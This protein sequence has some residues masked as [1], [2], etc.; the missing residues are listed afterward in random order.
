MSVPAGALTNRPEL[1]ATANG[2]WVHVVDVSDT[3]SGPDGTSK[4]VQISNLLGLE[5]QTTGFTISR[6]I[7]TSKT[8]TISENATISAGVNISGMLTVSNTTSITNTLTISAATSITASFTASSA[9]NITN[10]LTVSAAT[11]I[12]AGC[13]ISNTF[14]ANQAVSI[15]AS[16]TI[17]ATTSITAGLTVNDTTSITQPLTVSGTTQITA[18]LTVSNTTSITNT[19]TANQPVSITGALTISNTTSITNT[20]TI[21]AATSITQAFT[22]SA[23]C[24]IDQ[25]L[26]TSATVRFGTLSLN[27][28]TTTYR[29]NVNGNV[30]IGLAASS[31]PQIQFQN[32]GWDVLHYIGC[33]N[34]GN[35]L[36]LGAN[37]RKVFSGGAATNI[38]L[39]DTTMGACVITM[40]P[41]NFIL[42][43]AASGSSPVT[44]IDCIFGTS[45]G[46]VAFGQ[47]TVTSGYQ[48]EVNGKIKATN[49]THDTATSGTWTATLTDVS[50]NIGALLAVLGRYMRIDNV[51]FFEEK[52]DFQPS[53]TGTSFTIGMSLPVA[54]NFTD[55]SNDGGGVVVSFQ[56]NG[57]A[58]LTNNAI[59][60]V[61]VDTSND[62]LQINILGIGSVTTSDVVTISVVGSYLV[63]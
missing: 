38:T 60:S 26:Q 57:S 62:R 44:P 3:S 59:A 10:T 15:T 17:S 45:D 58:P 54:S 18:A 2:D 51:V 5:A 52:I 61:T 14:L 55:A 20:L 12:T 16:L 28:A 48:V 47:Q 63:K 34:D 30:G 24:T 42:Q 23:S 7:S 9:V 25:N 29:L 53:V 50:G 13:T 39:A 22:V 31:L 37:G 32:T 49:I 4:K 40:T 19:F 11:S 1:T 43:M 41:T 8:L 35:Q 33:T 21:S 27:S 56:S 46:K 36:T 6:G